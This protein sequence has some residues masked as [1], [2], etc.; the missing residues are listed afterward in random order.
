[1]LPILP[2]GFSFSL[3]AGT[4]F[5]WQCVLKTDHSMLLLCYVYFCCEIIHPTNSSRAVIVPTCE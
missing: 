1:M 4:F 3:T 2:E 5:V